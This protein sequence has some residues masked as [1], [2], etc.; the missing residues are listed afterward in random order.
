MQTLTILELR[1]R[2]GTS[3]VVFEPMELMERLAA[4]VPAPPSPCVGA[5][6]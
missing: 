4:L 1:W 5:S 6:C 2:D 3:H